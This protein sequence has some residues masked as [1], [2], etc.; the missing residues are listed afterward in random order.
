VSDLLIA[1]TTWQQAGAAVIPV[2]TDGSK[3]PGIDGH[4][5]KWKQ[6]EN[7]RPTIEDI[8]DWYSPAGRTDGL[9]ILTGPASRSKGYDLEMLELE[10]RAV[11]EGLLSQLADLCQ[12]NGLGALWDRL[13]AGYLEQTP[14]GGLHFIYRVEEALG[15]TKLARRPASAVELAANPD[16]RIK[17]LIE[18]RGAGGFVVVAPSAGRTHG[19]G[20][21]YD[22]ING[23]PENLATLSSDERDQL[24]AIATMLDK[25][26]VRD[27]PAPMVN[28]ATSAD[29]TRPGDD[30]N[31]RA[32]WDEILTARGW[33]R[34]HQLGSGWAWRR[35]GKTT[36]ISATTGQRDD[37]DRLYVFTTS[38]EFETETPYTKFA[39][40]THLEHGGDYAQAAK[41]LAGAG[42]GKARE[43]ARPT[44]A[45]A[46]IVAPPVEGVVT[47]HQGLEVNEPKTYTLSDDGNAL[48]LVDL[49]GQATR[50]CAERGSWMTWDGYRWAWDAS[51]LVREHA[52]GVARQLAGDDRETKR[53]RDYS[54]SNRGITSMVR[55]AQTDRRIIVGIDRLDAQPYELNTPGG[56]V[57]LRTGLIRPPDPA[58]LHTRSTSIAPDF[59]STPVR[60]LNF[61]ATTFAGDPELT[62][63][64]QRL[65]GVSLVGR[66]L[67]Q[68]L[69][70]PH[71]PG[72]NGKST[73]LDVVQSVVGLGDTGYAISAPAELLLDT[74]NSEHPTELARLAG[75]RLV[76]TSEIE[77]GK[78]FA[79][80]KVKSLT[81]GDILSARF[82]RENYFN[83]TPT[84]TLWLLGNH[85]PNVR[86]GG[87][88][89]W[90]RIRLIPFSV[91][92]PEHQR[93][94]GFSDILISEEGPAILAWLING[95]RDY[96]NEGL[97]TP[98]SVIA[99][100]NTYATDQDFLARF[101]DENATIGDPNNAA[102]R[103]NV[104]AMRQAYETWCRVEGE[105]PISAKA[106]TIALRDRYGVQSHRANTSRF[107]L[108]IRLDNLSPDE[109]S[110]VSPDDFGWA[111]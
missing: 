79:E 42:Y 7:T 22:V 5:I 68:L 59:T 15:N 54:L 67:E 41:T 16:E 55:L 61:L 32:T 11:T 63:Y 72:A 3:A 104:A 87:A 73:M 102:M 93:I 25:M 40:Y 101:I 77:E 52:R 66:V 64:V 2:N 43:E 44:D 53:H 99:A 50:Y 46:G 91:T 83:F 51:E 58:A 24:F 17:V 48:R 109:A 82:M 84:H 6:Y 12:D 88:A 97:S 57:D 8:V 9:G 28:A 1:A 100:T 96:L 75:A 45:F 19:S 80:A 105:T 49:F 36:G 39:A 56:I 13:N 86:A 103:T 90:R 60:W 69:P 21:P 33:T 108:G 26:P 10:G 85:Q 94:A 74:K 62:T 106:L 27:S 18:T 110:D 20:K 35:P 23:D 14:S 76:V 38:T 81:G 71:G 92:V 70:F 89:F 29:G 34:V 4:L 78:R 95:A 30:Y 98:N 47:A 107:Y 111:R 65:L 31:Q 37:A